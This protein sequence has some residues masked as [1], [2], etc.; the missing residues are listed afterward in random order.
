MELLH[1]QMPWLPPD[2]TVLRVG[3]YIAK[4][5]VF[6]IVPGLHQIAC[7][8]FLL[9]G[10]LM[11]VYF[12]AEFTSSN[13][14]DNLSILNYKRNF[15]AANISEYVCYFSWFLLALDLRKLEHRHLKLNLFLALSCI[16]G[17]YYVPEHYPEKLTVYVEKENTVCPVF[18][19]NDIV[20]FDFNFW[21]VQKKPGP[22]TKIWK[23]QIV[24]A[25]VFRGYPYATK[26]L[27]APDDI[28]SGSAG[29]ILPLHAKEF[30][31]I[32]GYKGI[33]PFPYLLQEGPN[34][35]YKRYE[36]KY[37]S[38]IAGPLI[39][40]I[41]P[42]KIGNIREYYFLSNGISDGIGEALLVVYKMTGL[43]LFGYSDTQ[44]TK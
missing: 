7:R 12:A 15:I 22:D 18:C 29:N 34:P 1:K 39:S 5:G 30:F 41:N 43:N 6:I 14:P 4:L 21:V 26:I 9:G 2:W 32:E 40:G 37:L 8:R 27:A 20:E 33:H 19:K 3:K 42:R 31:C 35:E 24:I 11:V 44:K 16:A 17:V 25:D 28:C 10:L 38:M 13:L 23:G 36:D